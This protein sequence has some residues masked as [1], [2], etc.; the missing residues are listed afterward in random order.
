MPRP[1]GK[2][3]SLDS[4]SGAPAPAPTTPGYLTPAAKQINAGDKKVGPKKSST[5]Q[6][7]PDSFCE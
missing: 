6:I 5:G 1:T 3:N 4:Y 2:H 7:S